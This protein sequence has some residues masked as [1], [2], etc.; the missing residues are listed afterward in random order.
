MFPSLYDTYFFQFK[1][2]LKCRLQ[3]VSILDQSKILSSGN[4]LIIAESIDRYRV[5][6][7]GQGV[8]SDENRYFLQMYSLSYLQSKPRIRLTPKNKFLNCSKLKAFADDKNKCNLKTDILVRMGRKHCGKKRKCWLPAFS[9]FS[10]M[11]SK[12]FSFSIV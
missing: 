11:F 1:C 2:T 7:T 12:G 8:Q 5:T 6:D 4:G 3:F 10:A 9:P